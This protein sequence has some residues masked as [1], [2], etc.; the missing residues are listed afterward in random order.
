[1]VKVITYMLVK[2][3]FGND[4]IADGYKSIYEWEE[5]REPEFFQMPEIKEIFTSQGR[6]GLRKGGLMT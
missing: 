3:N 2:C 1:M 4:Q 6:K 5:W